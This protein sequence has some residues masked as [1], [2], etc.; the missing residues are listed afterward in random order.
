MALFFTLMARS[1]VFICLSKV[2]SSLI[3]IR[4]IQEGLT[5]VP[6]NLTSDVTHLT[7]EKNAIEVLYNSS[8]SRYTR[9]MF[10]ALSYNPVWKIS[11]G[12][13]DNNPSL[14]QLLCRQCVIT[15][16]PASF[17]A[18]ASRITMLSLG[19]GVM[20]NVVV[21]P[22]FDSFVSLETLSLDYFRLSN[23][24]D[25]T[26]PSTIRWLSLNNNEISQ[27]PNLCSARLPQLKVLGLGYNRITHITDSALAC[28]SSTLESVG[29]YRNS[30]REI[31]DPT[32]F[33]NLRNLLVEQNELETFPDILAG[34][35]RLK[36][37]WIDQN[38]RMTCD[39]RLCWRRLWDRVRSP[40]KYATNVECMAPRNVRGHYLMSI[41][42][43]F[44]QC[45][46]GEGW[47]SDS[48]LHGASMRPTA[49]QAHDFFVRLLMNKSALVRYWLI[50]KCD[51]YKSIMNN[52]CGHY[53]FQ[54][55]EKAL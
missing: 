16:L 50:A 4:L 21:S 11:N 10:L 33:P 51:I 41:S 39:H 29:L 2:T 40:I 44:M 1:F 49:R 25:I 52:F 30:L 48:Y 35:S 34:L 9:L 46:Q 14:S 20:E 22:Y 28:M 43:A 12:T 24:D 17:G 42:P 19:C 38:T 15:V 26:L 53:H 54:I 36:G 3:H 37:F 47:Y 31:G 23:I 27:F 5:S 18:A 45:D 7:L 32:V 13:F 6:E 55:M 8:F